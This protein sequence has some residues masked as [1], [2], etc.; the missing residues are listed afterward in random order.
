MSAKIPLALDP[1]KTRIHLLPRHLLAFAAVLLAATGFA[2]DLRA[3]VGRLGERF[4]GQGSEPGVFAR[5][6]T[7]ERSES[8][9][10]SD[11]RLLATEVRDLKTQWEK[12]RELEVADRQRFADILTRIERQLDRGRSR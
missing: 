11:L 12:Q 9:T 4:D 8:E 1:E 5:I 3:E 6:S 2:Y 7:V 10:R